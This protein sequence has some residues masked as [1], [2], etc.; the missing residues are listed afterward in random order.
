MQHLLCVNPRLPFKFVGLTVVLASVADDQWA[1]SPRLPESNIWRGK[2]SGRDI[3]A[4]H[5]SSSD[6]SPPVQPPSGPLTNTVRLRYRSRAATSAAHDQP[7]QRGIMWLIALAS[8]LLCVSSFQVDVEKLDGLARARVEV[9]P[10]NTPWKRLVSF[11]PTARLS[12]WTGLSPTFSNC[13]N[14]CF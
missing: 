1:A 6:A 2:R 13:V 10:W 7:R 12:S 4:H 8:Y 3:G 9:T 14:K 11:S 5:L